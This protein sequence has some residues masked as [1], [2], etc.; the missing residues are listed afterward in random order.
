MLLIC[1]GHCVKCWGRSRKT[2]HLL[3]RRLKPRSRRKKAEARAWS[4]DLRA[5][6]ERRGGRHRSEKVSEAGHPPSHDRLAIR[7]LLH[8]T[9][10]DLRTG[11]LVCPP[12]C[13]QD[14]LR[15]RRR[16]CGKWHAA[17]WTCPNSWPCD[18]E[19]L[20]PPSSVSVSPQT[21]TPDARLP[22]TGK[23]GSQAR[24]HPEDPGSRACPHHLRKGGQQG[25]V[26]APSMREEKEEMGSALQACVADR[27]PHPCPFPHSPTAQ[28]LHLRIWTLQSVRCSL[29]EAGSAFTVREQQLISSQV[30]P[31]GMDLNHFEVMS[32]RR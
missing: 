2:Q 21:W 19:Q 31:P 24:P 11:G 17:P 6:A 26:V 4:E 27:P 7:T 8:D 5:G 12:P 18:R 29:G 23:G 1:V 32:T 16:L 14:H 15:P 28:L 22:S 10:L 30:W 20:I 13:P 9:L 25:L 3:T